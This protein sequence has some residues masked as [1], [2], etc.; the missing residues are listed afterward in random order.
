MVNLETIRAANAI[1]LFAGT[2]KH[3]GEIKVT[4]AGLDSAGRV[5]L[6]AHKDAFLE[7]NATVDVDNSVCKGGSVHVF[8]ERVGLFD[9]SII[10]ARGAAGGGEILIGGDYR[11]L[12]PAVRNAWRTFVAPDAILN[13]DAIASG[14]GG[15]VIVWADDVTRFNGT[16]S[17]RGGPQ[18][19]DGG[20]V[21]TS[22]KQS[23]LVGN[24]AR[25][26]T[27]A[28]AGRVGRWLL[29]PKNI[30]VQTGGTITTS[31]GTDIISTPPTGI[32]PRE[33]SARQVQAVSGSRVPPAWM[34]QA[35]PGASLSN[36]AAAP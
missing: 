33:R 21:E 36:K 25:V 24:S 5:V 31:A 23:L 29:D 18:S 8:G 12:N 7:G 3:S 15:K 17:A 20:F 19:G 32:C 6:S 34:R 22:G 30:I 16:I 14:D 4:S 9:R 28:P 27:R 26:D 35:A 2:L 13:A 1:G 11:G 10:T